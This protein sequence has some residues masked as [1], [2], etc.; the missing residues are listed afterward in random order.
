MDS[1]EIYSLLFTDSLVSNFTFNIST[2]LAL[3]SMKIFGLYNSYLVILLASLAFMLA[4]CINYGLGIL[5]YNI[6]APLKKSEGT[7]ANNINTDKIRRNKYLPFF[8]LLS[9]VPFFGKFI[10]LFAGFCK[11]RP[12]L[13]I[14]IGS[15]SRLIYYSIF[16]L[17]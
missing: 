2:E 3:H 13:A 12:M 7:N 9:A 5:C 4:A 14:S 8:L 17:M 1:F 11:V 10:M 15:L 16:M 6:L